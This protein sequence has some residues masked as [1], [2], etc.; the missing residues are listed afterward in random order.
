[1]M[2]QYDGRMDGWRDA[3]RK[4]LGEMTFRLKKDLIERLFR[5]G[6]FMITA[7]AASKNGLIALVQ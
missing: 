6:V 7:E 1:M 4:T 5:A 3:R 2:V